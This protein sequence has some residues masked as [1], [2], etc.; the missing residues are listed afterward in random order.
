MEEEEMMPEH[1]PELMK[2]VNSQ[3]EGEAGVTAPTWCHHDVTEELTLSWVLRNKTGTV[4]PRQ[5]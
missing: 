2:R 5:A 3:S 4:K 1:F